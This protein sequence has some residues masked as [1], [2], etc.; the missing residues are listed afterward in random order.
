MAHE[1]FL[2]GNKEAVLINRKRCH[3]LQGTEA[4]LTLLSAA[5]KASDVMRMC[6]TLLLSGEHWSLLQRYFSHV[7]VA[8]LCSA[9]RSI[10]IHLS[11]LLLLSLFIILLVL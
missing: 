6:N 9:V 5:R 2:N 4:L 1:T 7:F 8:F 10:V 3:Q 11:V